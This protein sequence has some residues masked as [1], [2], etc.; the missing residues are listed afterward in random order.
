VAA[1]AAKTSNFAWLQNLTF[2]FLT[3]K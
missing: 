2:Y 3:S 1:T